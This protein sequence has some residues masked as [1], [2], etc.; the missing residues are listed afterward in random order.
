MSGGTLYDSWLPEEGLQPC[1]SPLVALQFLHCSLYPRLRKPFLL[2]QEL[3]QRLFI[4]ILFPLQFIVISH[5]GVLEELS[6]FLEG[7]VLLL[8]KDELDL[9]LSFVLLLA[10][11]QDVFD[12]AEFLD[13]L[14][15]LDG[16]YSFDLRGVVAATE[17]AHVD[18]LIFGQSEVC[19]Y[20]LSVDFGQG[21]FFV[22]E[23]SD[24]GR[25]S[26]D[27][28]ICVLRADCVDFPLLAHVAAL[29]F[30]LAWCLD[31]RDA[32]QS[33]HMHHVFSLLFGN[34]SG[35]LLLLQSLSQ[36]A[37]ILSFF[38]LLSRLLLDLSPSQQLAVLLGGSLAVKDPD[39]LDA[40]FNKQQGSVEQPEQV[41]SLIAISISERCEEIGV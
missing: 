15:C 34:V 32:H 28:T 22:V 30:C 8:R 21:L 9:A 40:I 3:P 26:E 10:E 31:H 17:D 2:D 24:H 36:V 7:K 39:R 37:N 38:L 27:Q 5:V 12:G 18:K 16:T 13:E 41:A 33:Q 35:P 14:V 25:R 11:V 6:R 29:C 23:V 1:L 20:S 4:D 19:H